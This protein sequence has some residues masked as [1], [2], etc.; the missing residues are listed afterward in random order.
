MSD[1]FESFVTGLEQV[2]GQALTL[3]GAHS[4]AYLLEGDLAIES[5]LSD[6]G[7]YLVTD[8]WVCQT[9]DLPAAQHELLLGILLEMNGYAGLM[10]GAMF[11]L[12]AQGRMALT[13][14]HPLA[15]LTTDQYL[16]KLQ[17]L[18]EQA[19]QMRQLLLMIHPVITLP[20]DEDRMLPD[21][22]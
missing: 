21:Q 15:Q 6:D 8:A 18:L 3:S 20:A 9:N 4:F 22:L 1:P 16:A 14:A 19:R 5:T 10:H 2:Q 12:D 11:S 13:L 17:D 7:R